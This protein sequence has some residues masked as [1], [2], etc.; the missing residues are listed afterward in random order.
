[1]TDYTISVRLLRKAGAVKLGGH[2]HERW[3][4]NGEVFPLSRG[5]KENPSWIRRL[6]RKVEANV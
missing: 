1:M 3:M 4:L 6:K 2:K 5:T